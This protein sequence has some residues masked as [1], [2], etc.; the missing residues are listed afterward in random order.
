MYQ[1]KIPAFYTQTY[2]MMEEEEEEATVLACIREAGDS[3]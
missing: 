3:L 2:S 1:E